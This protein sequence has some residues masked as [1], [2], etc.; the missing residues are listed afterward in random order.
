[1]APW[2]KGK[3]EEAT[4]VGGGSRRWWRQPALV[5]EEGAG[6]VVGVEA[7]A[8]DP[9]NEPYRS[10]VGIFWGVGERLVEPFERAASLTSRATSPLR[11]VFP[12]PN[13]AWAR[14]EFYKL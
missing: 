12:A 3:E 10:G 4:G 11:S 8:L 14:L 9:K 7:L 2:K 5:V 6:K 1:V 13:R